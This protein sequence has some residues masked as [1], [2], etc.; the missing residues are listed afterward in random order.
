MVNFSFD[1]LIINNEQ[2]ISTLYMQT[3]I[4]IYIYI[5]TRGVQKIRGIL[6]VHT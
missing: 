2:E 5:Y 6:E 4:Y 3:H 1:I